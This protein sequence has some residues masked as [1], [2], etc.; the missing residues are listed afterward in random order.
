[1]QDQL[2]HLLAVTLVTE[3]LLLAVAVVREPPHLGLVLKA[4]L[5]QE[6]ITMEFQ[7]VQSELQLL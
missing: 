4:V 2:V 3:T 5:L 7:A 1:V 6:V